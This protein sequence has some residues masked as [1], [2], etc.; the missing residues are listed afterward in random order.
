[1]SQSGL[2]P[3]MALPAR[4]AAIRQSV[5][6]FPSP[7]V[8]APCGS[9]CKSAA[10]TA[11]W[12]DLVTVAV[13]EFPVFG[14]KGYRGR[15]W[16]VTRCGSL[17]GGGRTASLQQAGDR[18]RP[19]RA[20]AQSGHQLEDRPSANLS[21]SSRLAEI[22]HDILDLRV[23]CQRLDALLPPE[24]APFVAAKRQSDASFDAVGVDPHLA[25]L[26][27]GGQRQ[28]FCEVTRPDAGHQSIGRS[29]RDGDRLI[30]RFECR[31]REHRAE[32]LLLLEYGAAGDVVEQRRPDEVAWGEL[33]CP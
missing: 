23:V 1:M 33:S 2:T 16:P 11:G 25:R 26:D 10:T 8:A 4:S 3:R 20:R 32:D 24:A 7:Q 17:V 14:A 12:P 15:R 31:D 29:V 19:E 21:H 30:D 27:G 22:D 6:G 13:H 28:R 9:L 5:R 18:R